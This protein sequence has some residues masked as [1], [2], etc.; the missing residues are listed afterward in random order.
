M[1][2]SPSNTRALANPC[3]G[4]KVTPC[5]DFDSFYSN[6]LKPINIST[7]VVMMV[8]VSDARDPDHSLALTKKATTN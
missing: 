2:L 3:S 4:Q 1:D 6:C 5:R 8:V 7:G